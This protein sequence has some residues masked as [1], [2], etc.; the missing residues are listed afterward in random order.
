MSLYVSNWSVSVVNFCCTV[1]CVLWKRKWLTVC[2]AIQ[3]V[4]SN[5]IFQTRAITKNEHLCLGNHLTCLPDVFTLVCRNQPGSSCPAN[6]VQWFQPD[7]LWV[8]WGDTV[9]VSAAPFPANLDKIY[10]GA[11]VKQETQEK[12]KKI[13]PMKTIY[14]MMCLNVR[15]GSPVC[16]WCVYWCTGS[17]CWF[18][19]VLWPSQD[20]WNKPSPLCRWETPSPGCQF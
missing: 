1:M 19:S 15:E 17:H 6:R 2:L 8:G 4:V 18:G 14:L 20:R 7:A 13:L 12:W 10:S 3:F 9:R 11:T 16:W 5:F